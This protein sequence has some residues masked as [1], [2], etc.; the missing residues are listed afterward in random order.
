MAI[1][2]TRDYEIDHRLKLKDTQFGEALLLAADVRLDAIARDGLVVAG[3][4]VQ[5]DLLAANRSAC[6]PVMMSRRSLGGFEAK[7]RAVQGRCAAARAR[8]PSALHGRP[9]GF[10]PTRG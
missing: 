9:R 1:S 4:S 3:Q 10:R 5:V 8:E 2:R 6:V 7:A